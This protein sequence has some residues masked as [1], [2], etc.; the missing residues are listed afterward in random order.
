MTPVQL[1]FEPAG[2]LVKASYKGVDAGILTLK[3][4]VYGGYKEFEGIQKPT[5]AIVLQNGKKTEDWTFESYRFPAA[6]PDAA[7]A[8]PQ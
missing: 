8:K 5:R 7:F 6:L 2:K 3:E 4:Y 1:Y